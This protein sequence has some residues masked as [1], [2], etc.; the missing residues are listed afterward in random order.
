MDDA[1][2]DKWIV[3]RLA[4]SANT[5]DL[6]MEICQCRHLSWSEAE[7]LILRVQLEQEHAISERQFPLLFVLAL[8]IFLGGLAMV[9]YYTFVLVPILNT[10]ISTL[11]GGMAAFSFARFL[12]EIGI[13]PISGIFFG[14][15]M[16]LG[17]ILGMRRAWE[18]MLD[19]ILEKKKKRDRP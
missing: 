6:I 11:P 12:V 14:A 17:S 1:T 2:L 3:D 13:G 5:N 19:H 16:I 7:A 15:A 18:P 9:V 8:F 10:L 4:K